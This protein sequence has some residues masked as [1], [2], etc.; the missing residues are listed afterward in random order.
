MRLLAINNNNKKNKN[1]D[2]S[3]K[4]LQNNGKMLISEFQTTFEIICAIAT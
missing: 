1:E 4:R 3:L 2:I